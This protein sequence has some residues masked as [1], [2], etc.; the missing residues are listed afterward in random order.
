MP[1]DRQSTI[2]NR[3]RATNKQQIS[4]STEIRTEK[5]KSDSQV[6]IFSIKHSFRSIF[7]STEFVEL[8]CIVVFLV[9]FFLHFYNRKKLTEQTNT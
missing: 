9:D 7:S 1:K 5:N 2:R 8:L 3:Q 4:S 6:K